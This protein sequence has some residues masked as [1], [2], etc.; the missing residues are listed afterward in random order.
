MFVAFSAIVIGALGFVYIRK[1]GARKRADA[2]A[3]ARS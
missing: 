2:P 3:A 1:R